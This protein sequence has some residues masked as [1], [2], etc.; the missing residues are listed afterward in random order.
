MK[1]Y[2]ST[3]AKTITAATLAAVF[4]IVLGA[5]EAEAMSFQTFAGADTPKACDAY[6]AVFYDGQ[7]VKSGGNGREVLGKQDKP[8]VSVK[9][10]ETRCVSEDGVAELAL[11]NVKLFELKNVSTGDVVKKGGT[12]ASFQTNSDLV[13]GNYRYTGRGDGG[14]DKVSFTI[15]CDPNIVMEPRVSA[16]CEVTPNNPKVGEEVRWEADASDGDGNYSYSWSGDVAGNRANVAVTYNEVGKKDGYITVRSDG[17][18]DVARCSVNVKK[19]GG[20]DEEGGDDG[21]DSGGNGGGGKNDGGKDDDDTEGEVK[22]DKDDPEA[23]T[24]RRTIEEF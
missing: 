15:D 20:D 5:A 22:G 1:L 3:A 7:C 24:F 18:Q 13:D 4:V 2:I 9:L 8:T 6:D 17:K 10:I 12:G 19:G 21:N 16:S 11:K 23:P 14:S